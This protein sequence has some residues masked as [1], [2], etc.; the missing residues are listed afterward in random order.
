MQDHPYP[1]AYTKDNLQQVLD[2]N[3][4]SPDPPLEQ[5]ER[6]TDV[7]MTRAQSRDED[8][9]LDDTE[10]E[11]VIATTW[12][13]YQTDE[14]GYHDDTVNRYALGTYSQEA[15]LGKQADLF[16]DT[17][18][19]QQEWLSTGDGRMSRTERY[20]DDDYDDADDGELWIPEA[21]QEYIAIIALS[22]ELLYGSPTV[23]DAM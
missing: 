15:S 1:E 13:S 8:S 22:D 9:A 2:A 4:S 16:T 21:A 18:V 14:F 20:V 19:L 3:D 12:H 10:V 17:V 5:V 6:I 7:A 23:G 11:C